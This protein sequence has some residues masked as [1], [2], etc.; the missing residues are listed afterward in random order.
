MYDKKSG[1]LYVDTN[2][3]NPGGQFQIA[4]LSKNLNLGASN[5]IIG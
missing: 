4:Q 3:K 1:G 2:G 5:F